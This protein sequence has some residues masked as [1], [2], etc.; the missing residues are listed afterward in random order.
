[1]VLGLLAKWKLAPWLQTLSQHQAL[2]WLTVPHAFRHVGMVFLV[3]G[4][5]VSPLPGSFAMPAAY[6]DLATALLALLALFV[7]HRS[8]ASAVLLVWVFNSE[9]GFD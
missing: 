6:G 9:Y 7:L 3:P 4:M 8:S 1:V 2:F 5:V